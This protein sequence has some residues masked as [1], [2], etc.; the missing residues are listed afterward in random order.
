MTLVALVVAAS[1]VMVLILFYI[2]FKFVISIVLC[3]QIY[4]F[5]QTKKN[6]ILVCLQ[7]GF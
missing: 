4:A 6:L 7:N 1:K 3:R 5:L 2:F